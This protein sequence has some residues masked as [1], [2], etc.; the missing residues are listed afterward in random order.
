MSKRFG[1]RDALSRVDLVAE[2]GRLHGLLGPN[3]A[4][5][6]TLMRILLGLVRRDSGTL[7]LLGCG[8]DGTAGSL[9]DGVAGFVDTP[10]FYPYLSGARNLALL[11]GLD[12]HGGA[13]R[14]T[15]PG[16]ALEQ[17]GLSGHA[18]IAVAHYSA[19]MRQRLGLAAALLRSP[20]LLLLDEPTN[21]LDPAGA[22]EVRALA[23]RLVDKGAAVVWS[24]HDMAEI[25]ELCATLTIINRGRVVFSG[26]V[27]ELRTLAP[28]SVH[29]LC[30]SDD[31]AALSLASQRHGLHVKMAP[32]T[33][34]GLEVSADD[35]ALDAYVIALGRAGVAVRVLQRRTRTLESLFLELTEFAGPSEATAPASGAA[36]SAGRASPVVS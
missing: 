33:D 8:L 27:D 18:E 6:T 30:T 20:Q 24:S 16:N 12:R 14:P 32:T 26:T 29:A 2:S 9:P 1:D 10:A 5:K 25:E 3:G 28:A 34:G 19:G 35:A 36:S 4:G 11:A 31:L 13:M 21:S 22:R 17:V 23:R 15:G 7:R